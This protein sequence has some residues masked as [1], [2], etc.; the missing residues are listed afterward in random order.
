M[1]D[2]TVVFWIFI[3]TR[4]ASFLLLIFSYIT[5]LPLKCFWSSTFKLLNN[6]KRVKMIH[7]LV[8]D[9]IVKKWDG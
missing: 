5:F 6:V 3:S 9:N 7:E 2:L 4:F 8:N 1:I